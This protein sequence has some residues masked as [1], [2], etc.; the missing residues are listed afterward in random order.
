M[1]TADRYRR[2]SLRARDKLSLSELK[3]KSEAIHERFLQLIES[4]PNQ[5]IFIYVSFRSEVDTITLI[6]KLLASGRIVTVPLVSMA[7]K[8]MRAVRLIDP[9][10]DLVPGYFGILEPKEDIVSERMVDPSTIDIVVM[11]GSAFDLRGGRL[12]Y[13][14]GFYD[15]FLVKKI[16][17]WANRI[18]LSFELQIHDQVPQQAHDQPVDFIISEERIIV[19]TPMRRDRPQ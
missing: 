14:G 9:E 5:T 3:K 12:G 16:S 1:E 19:G 10:K 7:S 11:P 8:S 6:G 17:S 18:A 15:R 2:E 4:I 13:G